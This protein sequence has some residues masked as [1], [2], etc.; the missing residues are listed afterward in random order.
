V[1]EGTGWASPSG[2]SPQAPAPAFPGYAANPTFASAPPPPGANTWAPPPKPGLVPLSPMTLGTILGASF[3]VLR[4][5]PR[6]IFLVSLIVNAITALVSVL[7]SGNAVTSLTTAFTSL[8]NGSSGSTAQ[9]NG[10]IFADFAEFGSLALV[11]IGNTFL[12]G[13]VS[14]EVAR[15][16]IGEKLPLQSLL[17]RS[18]GRL[19]PLLGWSFA[20][21]LAGFAFA[22]IVVLLIA[23]VVGLAVA[24]RGNGGAIAGAVLGSIVVALGGV[25]LAVWIGTKLSL[26]PSALLIEQLTL[27][28]AIG[29]SWRLVKGYFWRILGIQLL[30]AVI[31]SVASSIVE[32]PVGVLGGLFIETTHPTGV[33]AAAAADAFRQLTYIT[34][35]VDAVIRAITTIVASSAAALLYIDLRIRKEGLDLGLIQYMDA[36]QAGVTGAPDPFMVPVASAATPPPPPPMAPSAPPSSQPFA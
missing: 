8:A 36:R 9:L 35:V 22:V 11:Y 10:L 31:I 26:V 32:T 34:G 13:V 14:L 15:G 25:T 19:L 4:R 1:A 24:S 16:T 6:P 28:K 5:N 33:S 21:V 17:R 20:F 27:G 18:R 2:D 23:L 7:V 3:R 12:Q 30:V 29:R